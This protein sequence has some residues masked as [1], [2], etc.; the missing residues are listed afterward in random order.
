VFLHF[1]SSVLCPWPFLI[2]CAFIQVF[3]PFCLILIF[4]SLLSVISLVTFFYLWSFH[5]FIN[6]SVEPPTH[7]IRILY[8]WCSYPTF[9]ASISFIIF[10]FWSHIEHKDLW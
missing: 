1:P 6:F 10:C 2:F 8:E 5:P 3:C 7:F 9:P 4:H